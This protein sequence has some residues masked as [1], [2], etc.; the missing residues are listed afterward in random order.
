[1]GRPTTARMNAIRSQLQLD[2]DFKYLLDDP[3]KLWCVPQ[4]GGKHRVYLRNHKMYLH[5]FIMGAKK[6]QIVDHIDGNPMNNRR[7]NLRIVNC[8]ENTWNTQAHSDNLFSK[9][10]G[11]SFFRWKHYKRSKP[12]T[13]HIMVKGKA[14]KKYFATEIEAAIQYNEWAVQFYGEYAVLNDVGE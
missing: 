6:G 5:R 10:K 13:A 7:E 1:M 14:Y 11:V 4:T 3:G 12:W 8:N 9:F 2:D